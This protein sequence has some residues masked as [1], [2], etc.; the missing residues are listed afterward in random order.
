MAAPKTE[1]LFR[2]DLQDATSSGVEAT[3]TIFLNGGRLQY[4]SGADLSQQI[5]D[6]V[7]LAAA[8]ASTQ[9]QGN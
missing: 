2:L 5:R 7:K 1:E 8:P 6:Q 9:R 3:P 4:S